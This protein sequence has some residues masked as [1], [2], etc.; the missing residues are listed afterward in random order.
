MTIANRVGALVAAALLILL[1]VDTL[2]LDKIVLPG[3][4]AL[5]EQGA[6]ED[7]R[8]VKAELDN[9]LEGLLR[10]TTDW[11]AWDDSYR[12]IKDRNQDF[13]QSNLETK[14]MFEQ[15]TSLM[16]FLDAEGRTVWGRAMDT[17]QSLPKPHASFPGQN[18]PPDNPLIN[19]KEIDQGLTGFI[20]TPLGPMLVASRPILTSHYQGPIR[21]FMIFG[22]LLDERQLEAVGKNTG[23]VVKGTPASRMAPNSP[24]SQQ[25]TRLTPGEIHLTT[26]DVKNK[27]AAFMSIFDLSGRPILLLS[28]EKTQ[29]IVEQG[30]GTMKMALIVLAVS[31]VLLM[32]VVYLV[33]RIHVTRPLVDLARNIQDVTAP[34]GAGSLP[35]S[36]VGSELADVTREVGGMLERINYLTHTDTLT[37]LPNRAYFTERAAHALALAKRNQTRVAILLVDLDGFKE[38]NDTLGYEAGDRLLVAISNMLKLILRESDTLARFGGDEF[39]L[40]AENL[41]SMTGPAELAKRILDVF[42]HPMPP[43]DIRQ[44]RSCSIGIA[45]FPDDAAT[46]DEL[47]RKA[48]IAMY[49]AKSVGGNTWRCHAESLN[50]HPESAKKE[51]PENPAP[52]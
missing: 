15:H 11:A 5:E 6:R 40:L 29:S 26:D 12:F 23:V 44:G 33:L 38:V 52:L 16:W 18:L 32:G 37:G 50:C 34:S 20:E 1:A 36:S 4:S 14:V 49:R 35:A 43:E 42:R 39:L 30:Q 24:E 41:P 28:S 51:G 21:G 3:F 8:R 2:V 48:D 22:K 13:I 31:G 46:L 17:G 47:L 9:E 25:M 19:L 7:M 10:L 27:I 45:I